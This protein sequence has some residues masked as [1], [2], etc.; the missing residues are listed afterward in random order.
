M[1]NSFTEFCVYGSFWLGILCLLV[2]GIG[3]NLR[4]ELMSPIW[5]Y[6]ALMPAIILFQIVFVFVGATLGGVFFTQLQHLQV[7]SSYEP[8]IGGGMQIGIVTG[9]AFG[10]FFVIW[11]R[12]RKPKAA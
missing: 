2:L 9:T 12:R 1:A 6:L 5:P 8:F 10:W 7:R 11:P 3:V 4:N